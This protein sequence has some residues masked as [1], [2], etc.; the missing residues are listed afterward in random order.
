MTKG[1]WYRFEFNHGPGHQSQTVQYFWYD[2]VLTTR[3]QREEWDTAAEQFNG[4][5][6]SIKA[7]QQLP[8]RIR[9]F[10]ILHCREQ[11]KYSQK[12]LKILEQTEISE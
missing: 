7:V 3:E 1:S 8:T 5:I 9:R 2:V 12:M 4:A 10:K 6:G 11:I